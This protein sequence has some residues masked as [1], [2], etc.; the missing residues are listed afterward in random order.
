MLTGKY[1]FG[2]PLP[3]GTRLS[4][5]LYSDRFFNDENLRIIEALLAF[6][7]QRGRN[8]LE[9]AFVWLLAKPLV[10]SVIAG[11]SSPDQLL[12]NT[13]AALAV[14]RERTR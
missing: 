12:Q 5:K 4:N 14:E 2:A 10:G 8:L 7:A 9:L 11:A 13:A 1:R 3:S 6:C